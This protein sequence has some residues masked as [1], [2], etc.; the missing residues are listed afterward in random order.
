MEGDT[1]PSP[2]DKLPLAYRFFRLFFR[3]LTNIWFREVDVV[4]NEQTDDRGVLFITWHPNGLIDPMVMTSRLHGKLTTLV[5]HSL[6]RIP[7]I[8]FFFRMAG[9]VALETPRKQDSLANSVSKN[10]EILKQMAHKI[11]EGSQVLMFPEET[12]HGLASVQK[13]RS[14][15]ARIM[16]QALK[17]SKD[18][19]R[20]EPR[21]IPI[22]LHY[23]DSSRFRERAA[24]VLE[25]PMDLPELPE[26]PEQE[27]LWIDVVTAAIETELKRANLSKTSWEERRLIWKGRSVIYAEKQRQSGDSI[28][29]LSY[30]ESILGARR[31][32]AGWEYMM[33]HE[34]ERTQTLASECEEH[35]R[36]LERLHL[37]PYDV[38]ARPK[39]LDFLG[40]FR[41]I[42]LWLWSV[43]WMF[44]LVTWGAMVG[45]YVPY[46]FQGFLEWFTK[47]AR[48]D[49]SLQGSI[50]VLSS[51]FIFPLWWAA[52]SVTMAWLLQDDASPIFVFLS[53]NAVLKYV[54]TLPSFGIFL[55]FFFF[56]PLTAKAH[57][58]LYARFVQ[59][60]R[61]M[62]QWKAW[63]N[64]ST[65]W[66]RLIS[67]QQNLALRLVNIGADLV[68]PGDE[69]WI[70]PPAG[71]DDAAVVRRREKAAAN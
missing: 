58:K 38:D 47:K 33:Q 27:Q 60:T 28:T 55:F 65:D 48:V 63:N 35:F 2:H 19:G 43:V 20:P 10:D 69:E 36:H 56:W 49:D 21:L 14:G 71:Q 34:P 29:R 70:D 15:A 7:F 12:T 50:K 51:M 25:R 13:I 62:S 40:L 59:S 61:R 66:D 11:A 41:I 23:S 31:L 57:M 52:M 9:V 1:A 45:N 22:G 3:F 44:G 6:F 67:T 39:Q 18:M 53:E 30:A 24:I 32:R 8:G 16:L 17:I 68:L 54:T 4:D 42:A 64:D 26:Q 46:K 5:Q 37:T